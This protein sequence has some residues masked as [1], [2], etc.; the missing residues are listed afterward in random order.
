MFLNIFKEILYSRY[1]TCPKPLKELE[2][3][4]ILHLNKEPNSQYEILIIYKI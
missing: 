2:K 1:N 3:L 4:N